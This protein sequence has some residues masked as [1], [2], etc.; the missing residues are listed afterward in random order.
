M[1]WVSPASATEHEISKTQ[2]DFLKGH[3]TLLCIAWHLLKNCIGGLLMHFLLLGDKDTKF[4]RL[5]KQM[6][7]SLLQRRSVSRAAVPPDAVCEGAGSLPRSVRV[8]VAHGIPGFVTA[9]RHPACTFPRP[10]P[11][12]RVCFPRGSF[13]RML[14]NEFRD[15]RGHLGR[16]ISKLF[17]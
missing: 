15:L 3:I 4:L 16:L 1:S 8:P 10:P 7:G 13:I 11:L 5:L 17:T 2:G 14:A 6:G 12:C 9:P